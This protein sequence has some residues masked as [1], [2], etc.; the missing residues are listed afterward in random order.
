MPSGFWLG[1]ANI[2]ISRDGDGGSEGGGGVYSRGSFSSSLKG[3]GGLFH[4]ATLSGCPE[5]PFPETLQA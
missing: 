2:I 1:L 3:M 4:V 5:S